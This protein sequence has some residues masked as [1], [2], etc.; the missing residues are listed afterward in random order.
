VQDLSDSQ[1]RVDIRYVGGLR[2]I[3]PRIRVFIDRECAGGLNATDQRVQPFLVNP[4][5]H[6]VSLKCNV[7]RSE[8]LDVNLSAGERAT[9]K[10]GFRRVET[11]GFQLSI[12]AWLA[13]SLS[14]MVG[15]PLTGLALGG[16]GFVAL[17]FASWRE[18][19]TPGAYLYLR[20]QAE[21]PLPEAPTPRIMQRPR[22]TIRRWMFLVAAIAFVLGAGVEERLMHRRAEIEIRRD[23]YR[24]FAKIH[25]DEESHR[26]KSESRLAELEASSLK[27]IESLSNMIRSE[28]ERNPG[29]TELQEAKQLLDWIRAQRATE[30]QLAAYAAQSKEKYLDA[31]TR[32]WEPVEYDPFRR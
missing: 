21:L 25:A 1:A 7:W 13:T 8:T 26:R 24:A 5:F 23:R 17:G 22:M 30:A 31:A 20:P 2:L 6:T 27:Y 19:I 10:S 15:L 4:G 18:Y 16:L 14:S 11:L 32:P 3:P 12:A 29:N 9:L 28:P